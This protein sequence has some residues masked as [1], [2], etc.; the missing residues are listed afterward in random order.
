MSLSRAVGAPSRLV[1]RRLWRRR[2]QAGLL[3]AA[4]GAASALLGWSG[5]GVALAQEA[6][7]RLRLEELPPAERAF[8]VR[9]R[10]LDSDQVDQLESLAAA[11]T[12]PFAGL[13]EARRWLRV[14]DPIAPA[15]ERGTRLVEVDDP[16]RAVTVTAGRLPADCQASICEALAL[17]P[18]LQLGQHI[19]LGG[20]TTALLVGRGVLVP[21]ALPAQPE[22]SG[23]ALLISSADL[24]RGSLLGQTPSRTVALTPLRPGAVRA[25][26]LDSMAVRLR[27]AVVRLQRA[28]FQL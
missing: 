22:V 27:Q 14:W 2:L 19:P 13:V 9:Y 25:H 4:F 17:D 18:T 3:L 21:G 1:L 16:V 12:T 15:D 8:V 6:S 7:V 24:L 23:R 28:R 11:G 26:A 20:G 5:V 10:A